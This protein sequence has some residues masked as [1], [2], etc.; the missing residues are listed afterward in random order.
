MWGLKKARN[1]LRECL[2]CQLKE[3][4]YLELISKK[5]NILIDV[6][7]H[8]YYGKRDDKMIKGTNRGKG[9]KNASLLR[10]FDFIQMYS[11]L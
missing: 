11:L 5:V 10:I 9:K 6:T 7:E 4:L 8:Y 3:A 1:I 2:A